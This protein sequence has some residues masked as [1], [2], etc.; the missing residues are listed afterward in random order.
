MAILGTMPHSQVI[1]C[2]RMPRHSRKKSLPHR[3]KRLSIS[4]LPPKLDVTPTVNHTYRYL[5]SGAGTPTNTT[6]G[7]LFGALGTTCTVTNTTVTCWYTSVRIV[8]IR[9]YP[10]VGGAGSVSVLWNSPISGVGRDTEPNNMLPGGAT[11]VTDFIAYPPAH[12]FCGDWMNSSLTNTQTI[13]TISSPPG[14]IIDLHVMA[15]NSNVFGPYQ[16]AITTGTLAFPY[17]LSLDG[18]TS[19][20]VIPVGLP[21]TS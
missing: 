17:Y 2:F 10:V 13:F 1:C 18:T 8:S 7:E 6:I 16:R 9:I 19:N 14:S 5:C 11:M 3:M 15:T 20:R 21:T 12:S 4:H